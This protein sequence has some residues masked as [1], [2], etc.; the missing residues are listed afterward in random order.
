MIFLIK[1]GSNIFRESVL[2]RFEKDRLLAE[3]E[4][5]REKTLIALMEAEEVNESKAFFMAAASHVIKQPLFSLAMLTDTLLMSDISESVREILHKQRSNISWM[6]QHFDALM[7]LSKFEG[8][9]FEINYASVALTELGARIDDEF[10]PL[11]HEKGL[12]WQ[13]HMD[14]VELTTDVDLLLR[15]IR[16][17]LGNAIRYTQAGVIR[18]QAL[19]VGQQLEFT[20]SD[21][22]PG[23]AEPDQALVFKQYV[24]LENGGQERTGAGLG[25]AIV[26][27]ID[28]VLDLQLQMKS[29]EGEGTSFSFTISL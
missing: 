17:I 9:I 18:C 8:G 10:A 5:E 23:I 14:S 26:E 22:G 28:N 16:N 19:A 11:C 1:R 13:I 24:R 4:E 21:T 12:D 6:S 29:V 7:D 15:L 2:M 27:H 25:L 3:V 20:I